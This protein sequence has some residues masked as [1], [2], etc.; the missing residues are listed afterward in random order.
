[1]EHQYGFS[2]RIGKGGKATTF[3][4]PVTSQHA[5]RRIS[6][7]LPHLPGS[8]AEKQPGKRSAMDRPS[9]GLHGDQRL[10]VECRRGFPDGVYRSSACSNS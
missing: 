8:A 7:H 9:P 2:P 3:G 5:F 4:L 6:A 1:M 10:T